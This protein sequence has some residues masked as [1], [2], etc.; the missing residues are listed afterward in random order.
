MIKKIFLILFIFMLSVGFVSASDLNDTDVLAD[1]SNSNIDENPISVQENDNGNLTNDG[2]EFIDASEAYDLLNEFRAEKGAWYWLSDDTS[3]AYFNTVDTNQLYPLIRNAELEETAKIRAKEASELFEHLRPDGSDI[4]TAFPNTI[5][6]RGECLARFYMTCEDVT[7]GWK[8]TYLPFEYQGH[9]RMM[10][11]IYANC[12]GIAGYRTEDGAMFWAQ[13]YGISDNYT[14]FDVQPLYSSVNLDVPDVI[15]A[16]DDSEKKLEITLTNSTSPISNAEVKIN[17]NGINY[18]RT[19]NNEGKAFV[20][21][22]LSIGVHKAVVTYGDFAATSKINIISIYLRAP[23][24]IGVYGDTVLNVTLT[25]NSIPLSGE[26]IRVDVNG[27]MAMFLST[28]DEGIARFHL[29]ELDAG[30]YDMEISFNYEVYTKAKVTINK[31]PTKIDSFQWQR[32][33]HNSVNLI[34]SITPSISSGEMIFTVNGKNYSSSIQDSQASLKLSDLDVGNYSFGVLYG[35]DKNHNSSSSISDSNFTSEEYQFYFDVANVTKYFG[36]DERLVARLYDNDLKLFSN[37]GVTF[38]ING[39]RYS[40]TTN[41]KGVASMAINL[42]SGVYNITCE[43]NGIKVFSTVTV[44]PTISGRDV[45]KIYRNGTQYYAQFVDTK[46]NILKNT[47]VEFNING[48]FYIRTTNASGVAKMNIN[49]NPGEY[50]ITA[51]NPNSTERHSNIVRV[52]PNIVENNNLTKYYK[53]ASQYV[54]RLLDDAGNPVGAGE[55][56]E[57]NI[58]G[59]FY[60]R[61]SNATGHV[62]MNINLNPGTYIITANYKGLM[63]SNSIT[64]KPIIGAGD[65]NMRYKDGSKFETLLLDGQGNPFADQIITF[66]INGVFYN[67]TTDVNGIARLNINL[68]PGEYIITSM[69][70]NGAA[71]SNRVTILG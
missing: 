4:S 49:L 29:N 30:V 17:I 51:T 61:T 70:E 9:R 41:D 62:K 19:T 13:A 44:K 63:A 57:F 20:D 32:L 60:N 25:N 27:T 36:G 45:T 24:V 15:K 64:V 69:Y 40:R 71:I 42:N 48:V 38:D 22:N 16:Y 3:K 52:L 8:E 31:I 55:R 28:N 68:I 23:D 59:V 53:N 35:G 1:D 56:V 39:R 6:A 21:L 67:R 7:E 50:I 12:V 37:C 14:Q 47:P 46:G 26:L 33:S 34:A 54:I 2:G 10:L 18:T 58:N 11:D 5:W 65:L 66:N 43:Y